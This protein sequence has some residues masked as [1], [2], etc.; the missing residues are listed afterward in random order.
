MENSMP[1]NS[2]A[3]G[4]VVSDS[5]CFNFRLYVA[6]QTPKSLTAITNLKSVCEKHLPGAYNIE[7]V[8]IAKNPERAI[9]DQIM[10]LPT[11]VRRLPEPIKRVIGT[12]SDVEKVLVGLDIERKD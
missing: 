2:A 5:E 1:N 10:A 3:I 4:T 12:L 6:G 11:L 9:E 8:D 7:I